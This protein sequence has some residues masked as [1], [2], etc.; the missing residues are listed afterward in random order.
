MSSPGRSPLVE[1][2]LERTPSTASTCSP[3]PTPGTTTE[4]TETSLLPSSKPISSGQCTLV[5]NVLIWR[6]TQNARINSTFGCQTPQPSKRGGK[7]FRTPL[8][9]TN[10]DYH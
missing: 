7:T 9:E 10:H 1:P 4:S 5:L 6:S 8:K 2:P 3:K